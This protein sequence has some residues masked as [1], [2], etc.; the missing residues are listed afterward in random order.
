MAAAA[1]NSIAATFMN[2]EHGSMC[3]EVLMMMIVI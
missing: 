1:S 2:V 3:F